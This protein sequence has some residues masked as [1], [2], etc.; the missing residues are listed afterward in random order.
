MLHFFRTSGEFRF[1]AAVN[2]VHL[3]AQTLGAAGGIHCYVAAAHHG[4]LLALEGHNGGVGALAVGLHE[5]DTGEEFI[6]G[7]YALQVL[8]GDVH[9]HG[10][11]RAGT[12][13]HGFKLKLLHQLINGDGAAHYGVG[14]NLYAQLLEAV[15][16]LL[17]DGLGQTELGDTVDQHAAGE[18]QSLKH[19]DFISPPGQVTGAGETGGTGTNN[20][21][22]MAVR[23]R[24]LGLLRGVGIVPVGN[25]PLQAAN[26]YA[27][28]LDAT[29]ALALALG[30]LGADASADGGQGAVLGNNLVGGLKVA[31]R[32][33]GN[34]LGD[35]NLH[36]TAG[37][38]GHVLAVEAALGL[39]DS[40]LLGVAKGHL[41]E[42]ARTD[43]RVLMGHGILIRTHIRHITLPPA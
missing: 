27:L 23:G 38:T 4:H 41:L 10:Q 2:D 18:V 32:Y 3:R 29:D 25:K 31:L 15:H 1:A 21:N 34:E 13:K 42:V 8:A 6:G 24:L 36:R 11:A 12:D 7:V 33:L 9:E 16:F 39:V 22:L 14:L 20:S 43:D 19:G 37:D 17:D 35:T 40:L 28:M 30:L 5:V 26:A